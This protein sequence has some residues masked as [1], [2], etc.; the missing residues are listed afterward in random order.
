MSETSSRTAVYERA[1]AR[2]LVCSF[3]AWLS[4][5]WTPQRWEKEGIFHVIG[6][7][8]SKALRACPCQ[9]VGKLQTPIDANGVERCKRTSW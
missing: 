4:G 3:I 6:T 9:T 2:I 5:A 8:F 7:A 1:A